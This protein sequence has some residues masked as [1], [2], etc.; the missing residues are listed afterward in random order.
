M[1]HTRSPHHQTHAWLASQVAIRRRGITR[2]LLVPEADEADAQ[3]DGFLRDLDHGDAHDAEDHRDS[4]ISECAGCDVRA[5]GSVHCGLRFTDGL[6]WSGG[7]VG[8][9]DGGLM[10][11]R[12]S[13]SPCYYYRLILLYVVC[14]CVFTEGAWW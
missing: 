13:G 6:S 1:K 9:I 11:V 4:E 12:M 10:G 5:C 3:V 8:D 2:G 7:G 14:V